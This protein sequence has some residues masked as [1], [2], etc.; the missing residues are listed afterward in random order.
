MTVMVGVTEQKLTL[1]QACELMDAGCRHSKRIWKRH[2]AEG[3]AGLVPGNGQEN[4]VP[5]RTPGSWPHFGLMLLRPFQNFVV[6]R[7]L[8]FIVVRLDVIFAHRMILKIV[9]HENAAQIG[10]AV[11]DD[12]VKVENFALLKLAAAPDGRERGDVIFVR[13]IRR[14]LAEDDRP[15]LQ[16]HRIKVIDGFETARDL[17]RFLH[18]LSTPSTSLFTLVFTTRSGQSTPV[19]LEQ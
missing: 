14:A 8:I 1:M 7:R 15:V 18:V 13:A 9:P 19:T 11:E 10:V 5:I 2:Q 3:D 17:R 12:A 16:R 4:G 6:R